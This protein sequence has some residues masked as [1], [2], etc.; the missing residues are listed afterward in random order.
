M[1]RR[2]AEEKPILILERVFLGTVNHHDLLMREV[3]N[4]LAR[5]D[6]D[7]DAVTDSGE[8]YTETKPLV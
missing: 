4:F 3:V 7:D 6:I 8:V 1:G 2:K 5:T